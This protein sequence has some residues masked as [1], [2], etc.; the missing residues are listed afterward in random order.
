MFCHIE[1]TKQSQNNQIAK[2]IAQTILIQNLS[3]T[4]SNLIIQFRYQRIKRKLIPGFWYLLKG[5]SGTAW[6]I[7]VATCYPRTKSPSASTEGSPTKIKEPIKTQTQI[8]IQNPISNNLIASGE[9]PSSQRLWRGRRQ[10]VAAYP[11]G[12]SS[13]GSPPSGS[14]ESPPCSPPS[15]SAHPPHRRQPYTYSYVN[16][17]SRSASE[18]SSSLHWNPR[19]SSRE[20]LKTLTL[21]RNW[22]AEEEEAQERGN[23]REGNEKFDN[24]HATCL[25]IFTCYSRENHLL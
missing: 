12:A 6:S 8:K 1:S 25:H 5:A 15:V 24:E 14:S 21:V 9:L 13:G 10:P 17:S 20:T 22:R 4:I 2:R 19:R 11:L 16:P 18:T 23:K 7:R 3:I